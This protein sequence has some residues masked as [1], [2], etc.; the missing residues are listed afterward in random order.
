MQ[1]P[2]SLMS[3]DRNNLPGQEVELG[4]LSQKPVLTTWATT[5]G[6]MSMEA[7]DCLTV[8]SSTG[9]RGPAARSWC[10]GERPSVLSF[11]LARAGD[12]ALVPGGIDVRGPAEW[13]PSSF[14]AWNHFLER[15][16]PSSTIRG[17]GSVSL[18]ERWLN[19]DSFPPFPGCPDESIHCHRR[20]GAGH[21]PRLPPEP[22]N[23]NVLQAATADLAVT[24]N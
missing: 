13:R 6:P 5:L 15:D 22:H 19:V 16:G 18:W 2:C 3:Y 10:R 12:G 11:P 14:V 20:Q 23:E 1:K 7:S 24:L 4:Q 17:T 21:L 9:R 8:D